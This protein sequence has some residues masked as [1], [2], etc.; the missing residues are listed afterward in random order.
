MPVHLTRSYKAR[1]RVAGHGG[2]MI[3]LD[4]FGWAHGRSLHSTG[5]ADTTMVT[6]TATPM[7][8]PLF[9]TGQLGREQSLAQ[10]RAGGG[11]SLGAMGTGGVMVRA[12][13]SWGAALEQLGPSRERTAMW[14]GG[15]A[16][17]CKHSA[18]S[19]ANIPREC[20]LVP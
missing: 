1:E 17:R 6:L 11:G 2:V 18:L 4:R 20:G 5:G 10:G 12:W 13:D 3:R 15:A 16:P 7:P 8:P 9:P 14:A 19:D